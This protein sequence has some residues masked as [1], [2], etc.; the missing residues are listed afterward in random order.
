MYTNLRVTLGNLQ[1]Q[2]V[3][4]NYKIFNNS[5]SQKW[6][7]LLNKD[8]KRGIREDDR[9]YGFSTGEQSVEDSITKIKALIKRISEVRPSVDFGNADFTNI[10]AEVNRIHIEFADVHLLKSD[11][12]DE[13]IQL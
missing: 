10:Q 7:S 9:F 13:L 1:Q 6:A 12:T 5:T 8:L 3:E 4:L 2:E 11:N